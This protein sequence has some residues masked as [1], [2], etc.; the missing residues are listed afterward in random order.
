MTAP[1]TSRGQ[2]LLIGDG[3]FLNCEGHTRDGRVERRRHARRSPRNN[4]RRTEWDAQPTM[5]RG[6]DARAYLHRWTF[7]PHRGAAQHGQQGA[8]KF[9]CG[10]AQRNQSALDRGIRLIRS[11]DDLRN[12]GPARRGRNRSRQVNDEHEAQGSDQQR[13]IRPPANH[14]IEIVLRNISGRGEEQSDDAK[15]NGAAASGQ[16]ASPDGAYPIAP[17]LVDIGATEARHERN[18]L[19]RP[20]RLRPPPSHEQRAPGE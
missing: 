7:T 1:M 4:D 9:E 19:S 6:H 11:G 8:E 20:A 10:G 5:R 15:D 2:A 13:R 12:P 14:Q 17:S 3:Q 16:S 18:P